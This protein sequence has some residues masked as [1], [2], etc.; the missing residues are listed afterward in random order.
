MIPPVSIISSS[1]LESLI[2]IEENDSI[3]GEVQSRS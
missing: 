3:L 2:E 1:M